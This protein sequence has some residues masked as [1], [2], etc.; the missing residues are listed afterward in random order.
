MKN[1][2][3]LILFDV[4]N[5]TINVAVYNLIKKNIQKT[6]KINTDLVKTTDEYY[7]SLNGFLN[8]YL[9]SDIM[10]AS[11]VPQITKIL[12]NLAKKFYHIDALLL[13]SGTKT[14]VKVITDNPKEVGA[15]LI[16]TAAA[17]T[18]PNTQSLIIDLGTATKYI[19]IKNNAIT[20]VIITPGLKISINAL[21]GNTA[22]LPEIEI[23]TPKKLLGTNTIECMQSGVTY[24]IAAQVDGL[25]NMIKEEVKEDF[26]IYLTGGYSNTIEPLL[27]NN[28]KISKD[29][30][31]LGLINIYNKNERRNFKW[32][33]KEEPNI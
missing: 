28:V 18:K 20:G 6:F 8:N 7:L 25:I 12:N 15:D 2:E 31:F 27:K 4:G 16:A 21:I 11:V 3:M 33:K 22:L 1:D 19:Y 17:V 32:L 13:E 29:L 10:I 14:G 23:K 26:T 24:G 9:I 5:T 30:I